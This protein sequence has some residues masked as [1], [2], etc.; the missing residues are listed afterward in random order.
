MYFK[1]IPQIPYDSKNDG[2]SKS[3]GDSGDEMAVY[4]IHMM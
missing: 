2:T 3:D 4:L 1:A